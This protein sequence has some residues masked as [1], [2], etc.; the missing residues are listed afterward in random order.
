MTKEFKLSKEYQKDLAFAALRNYAKFLRLNN[1][2]KGLN[3][4]R[5]MLKGFSNHSCGMDSSNS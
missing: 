1:D 5:F 3:E 2:R 4:L